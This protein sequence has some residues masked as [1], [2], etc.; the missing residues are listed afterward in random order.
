VPALA[1]V[2]ATLLGE[3]G[4]RPRAQA[5]QGVELT[6]RHHAGTRWIYLLNHTAEAQSVTMDGPYKDL[7]DGHTYSGSVPLPGYGVRVLQPA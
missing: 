4:I 3:A 5:P 1:R 6:M 7:L 2:L